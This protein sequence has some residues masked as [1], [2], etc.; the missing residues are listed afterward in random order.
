MYKVSHST[1]GSD[2]A[3]HRIVR[4]DA[5]WHQADSPISA[6]EGGAT[7]PTA[8]E[9]LETARLATAFIVGEIFDATA[10][11]G[12]VELVGAGDAVDVRDGLLVG[13]GSKVGKSPRGCWRVA[14]MTMDLRNATT[15]AIWG[16]VQK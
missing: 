10:R 1:S 5:V 8:S 15:I 12:L 11:E 4:F 7:A 9:V 2:T 13:E 6:G 16:I 3:S 14:T